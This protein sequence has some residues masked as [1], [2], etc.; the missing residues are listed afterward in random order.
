MARAGN[1]GQQR[2][3]RLLLHDIFQGN[4]IGWRLVS[5]NAGACVGG[6]GVDCGRR[7]STRPFTVG[8]GLPTVA[9]SVDGRGC[10]MSPPSTLV[11]LLRVLLLLLLLRTTS[12]DS[13]TD[14]GFSTGTS[15][16]RKST[17]TVMRIRRIRRV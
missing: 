5:E 1:R 13:A 2:L 10:T 3:M 7:V 17:V 16:S 15:A 9:S 4:A 14:M 12:I 6:F 11:L 8:L